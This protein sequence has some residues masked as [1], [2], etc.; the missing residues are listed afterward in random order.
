M[1]LES[2]DAVIT[3]P[4]GMNGWD[5]NSWEMSRNGAVTADWTYTISVLEGEEIEYKYVKGGA[6]IKKH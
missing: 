5:V 4:G 3:M 1:H 6:W 2:T